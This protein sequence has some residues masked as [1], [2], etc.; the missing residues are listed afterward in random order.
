MDAE[1]E[2]WR[3]EMV[4]IYHG[5][6]SLRI[7]RGYFSDILCVYSFLSIYICVCIYDIYIYTVCIYIFLL[8]DVLL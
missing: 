2:T 6:Y 3:P 8:G 4:R 1:I 5:V 7:S